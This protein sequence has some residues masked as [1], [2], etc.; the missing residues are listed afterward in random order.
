MASI[1]DMIKRAAETAGTSTPEAPAADGA[2]APEAPA[3][4]QIERQD[5]EHVRGQA[6]SGLSA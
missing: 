5:I 3:G 4:I 2:A 1:Q 6:K